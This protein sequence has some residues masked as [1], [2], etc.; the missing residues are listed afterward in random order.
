VPVLQEI[1]VSSANTPVFVSSGRAPTKRKAPAAADC[2]DSRGFYTS[3]RN[4]SG[5][6]PPQPLS[7]S[8][9]ALLGVHSQRGPTSRPGTPAITPSQPPPTPEN[10]RIARQMQM[11]Q[12]QAAS[13]TNRANYYSRYR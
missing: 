5:G 3:T 12:A 11:Q 1:T 7:Q 10:V 13:S 2:R 6:P 8:A 4:P 9:M